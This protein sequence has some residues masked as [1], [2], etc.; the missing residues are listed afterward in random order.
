MIAFPTLRRVEL[1]RRSP[2]TGTGWVSNSSPAEVLNKLAHYL[3]TGR[4]KLARQARWIVL[5]EMP[6]GS[7]LVGAWSSCSPLPVP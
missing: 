7:S 3:P 2:F 4:E 1:G 6:S 5:S